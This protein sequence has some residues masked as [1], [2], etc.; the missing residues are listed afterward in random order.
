[1]NLGLCYRAKAAQFVAS[2]P[3]SRSPCSKHFRP[4]GIRHELLS[5]LVCISETLPTLCTMVGLAWAVAF[6]SA[7]ANDC[8]GIHRVT[9]S[10]GILK[11]TAGLGI[12]KK[13]EQIQV[14][15]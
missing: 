6:D 14:G 12:V 8:G 9:F 11:K 7:I 13:R 5:H 1:M 10:P 4:L 15:Q 2:R 3:Q